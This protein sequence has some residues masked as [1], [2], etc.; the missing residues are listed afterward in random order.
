M[1]SSELYPSIYE[2]LVY[3]KDKLTFKSPTINK[4]KL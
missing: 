4:N 2:N 3:E 1:E